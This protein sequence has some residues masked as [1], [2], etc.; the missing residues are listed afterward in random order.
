MFLRFAPLLAAWVALAGC[1]EPTTVSLDGGAV[2]AST[3]VASGRIVIESATSLALAPSEDASFVARWL[4]AEG[5]PV[6]GRDVSFALEGM[7]R[8]ATLFSLGGRTDDDGRVAGVVIAGSEIATFRV[9]VAAPGASPAYVDVAVSGSGFGR[10]V[11]SVEGGEGRDI[12]QRTVLLHQVSSGAVPCDDALTRSEADRS[13]TTDPTGTVA[14]NTL[15]AGG[16]FTIV[17][18]ATSAAGVIVAEGCVADVAIEPDVENRA[19][20][21]LVPRMLGVEGEYEAEIALEGGASPRTAA[22]ALLLTLDASITAQGGD[23]ALLLGALEADLEARSEADALAALRTARA[24][25]DAESQ[26]SLL[27]EAEAAHPTGALHA[28]VEELVVL[29]GAI[30]VRGLLFVAGSTA[31][32]VASFT[33][34]DVELSGGAEPLVVDLRALGVTARA[35]MAVR[36]NDAADE[37]VVDAMRIELPIGRTMLAALE[38]LAVE[39]GAEGVAALAAEA[40]GCGALATWVADQAEVAPACDEACTLSVCRAALQSELDV[41]TSA[42]SA[43]D[44]LRARVVLSGSLATDD[45]DGNLTVDALRADALAGEWRSAD[46]SAGETVAATFGGDRTSPLP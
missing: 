27:L 25:G 44:L 36:W 34:G 29:H 30:G 31:G 19:S 20:V 28:L 9:R 8:D 14:F 13:R 46:G 4:D 24:S 15:P 16:R 41:I 2:D 26:L 7:P 37:L 5:S 12:A 42:A 21:P 35:P 43:L 10:L 3:P 1:N 32:P 22:D 39:R 33:R 17:A 6:A 18:R 23:A 45:G 11:V 38:A 40:A